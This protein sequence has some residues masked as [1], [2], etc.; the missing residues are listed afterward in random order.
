MVCDE[1]EHP[2]PRTTHPITYIAGEPEPLE[3]GY[4]DWVW[5]AVRER[6]IYSC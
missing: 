4:L 2:G 6:A 3:L 1:P 5:T